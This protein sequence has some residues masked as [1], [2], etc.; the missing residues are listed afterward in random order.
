MLTIWSLKLSNLHMMVYQLFCYHGN[1]RQNQC[2]LKAEAKNSSVSVDTALL[3]F[4]KTMQTLAKETGMCRPYFA[5]SRNFEVHRVYI[6]WSHHIKCH[7]R[8]II[9]NTES[10][11]G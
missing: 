9:Y 6:Q 4:S 8:A 2:F 1:W 7:I 10:M 5:H 11:K 3:S